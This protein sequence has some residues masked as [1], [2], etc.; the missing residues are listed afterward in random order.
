M[1]LR[2]RGAFSRSY[3]TKQITDLHGFQASRTARV[4]PPLLWLSRGRLNRFSAGSLFSSPR[5]RCKEL[6]SLACREYVKLAVSSALYPRRLQPSSCVTPDLASGRG[7]TAGFTVF[8]SR[9]ASRFAISRFRMFSLQRSR[10]VIPIPLLSKP[11]QG[12]PFG[13]MPIWP[14]YSD[15]RRASPGRCPCGT[16]NSLSACPDRG[17][18]ASAGVI[19]E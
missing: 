14:F 15:L 12:H 11:S 16:S 5:R 3:G 19:C 10:G 9:I 8:R 7:T 18:S 6:V 17:F 4:R 1:R 13:L 2:A